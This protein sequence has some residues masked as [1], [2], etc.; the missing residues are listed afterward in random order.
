MWVWVVAL[1]ATLVGLALAWRALARTDDALV[2]IRAAAPTDAL[3]DEARL[4]A[5]EVDRVAD[6]RRSLGGRLDD[7][8]A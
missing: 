7:P 2:S 6:R 1:L 5:T 8:R 3:A 4:L